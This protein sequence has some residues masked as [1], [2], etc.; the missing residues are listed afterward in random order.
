MFWRKEEKKRGGRGVGWG[1][2]WLGG[3]M[4]REA[5]LQQHT[6]NEQQCLPRTKYCWYG[7]PSAKSGTSPL[8]E[9]SISTR[10]SNLPSSYENNSWHADTNQ[11]IMTD[12]L[13][14]TSYW[15]FAVCHFRLKEILKD[16][17]NYMVWCIDD[18]L[19]T[20][21]ISFFPFYSFSTHLNELSYPHMPSYL[22]N[23]CFTCTCMCMHTQNTLK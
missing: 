2:G 15:H 7:Q 22:T 16:W 5:R 13:F 20:M 21:V 18:W 14:T 1:S 10:L 4:E 17:A 12:L 9:T 23:T 6:L 11:Q 8:Q 19:N 3:Q